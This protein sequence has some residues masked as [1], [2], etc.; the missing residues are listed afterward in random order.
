MELEPTKLMTML[1]NDRRLVLGRFPFDPVYH[2]MQTLEPLPICKASAV[3]CRAESY[4]G[5]SPAQ[6]CCICWLAYRRSEGVFTDEAAFYDANPRRRGSEECDWGV[7][8]QADG[9]RDRWRISYVQATGEIYATRT[10][11]PLVILMGMVP[12]DDEAGGLYCRTLEE[13]LNG[14]AV[15][16]PKPGGLEW[17]GERLGVEVPGL[18]AQNDT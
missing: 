17:V 10:P 3:G 11:T 5:E 12:P 18:G 15:R 14:W 8:W 4:A 16:C 2:L 1:Q 9:S 7:L 6:V 13:M